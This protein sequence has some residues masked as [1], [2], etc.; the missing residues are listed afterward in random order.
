MQD[1]RGQG[2]DNGSNMKGHTS[3]VQARLLKENSR[4]FFVPCA[5]HNY[6]LLLG[7][8]AKC[9]PDAISFFGILQAIYTL[10]SAS[11]KRWAVFKKYVPGLSVKPL[12]ITR[13][14]CRIDSVKAI[15]YQVGEVYGALVEISEITNEPMVKAEAESLANQLKDYKFCVSLIF[16]YEVLFKVNYVSKELQGETKD[17]NEGM[18]SF[19]KLLSWL[20]NYREEGFNDVLLGANELAESIELPTEPRKFYEKK[21][22]RRKRMFLYEAN[23][24][25][26]DDPKETYRVQCFNLVL[27]QAIQSLK[28]RFKQ[29]KNHVKLF[30]F[31]N[32]FQDIPKKEIREHT[33]KL[34]AALAITTIRQDAEGK[35]VTEK[36]KDVD[37]Y[38]LAEELEALK[39]FLRPRIKPYAL[40]EHLI[41]NNRFTTFPNVFIALRIYVR[42]PITVASGERSFS[43]LKLIKTYL[44]STVSQERLN[45]LSMLSIENEIAK[46]IDFENILSDFA[47]KKARKVFF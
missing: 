18:E 27:D 15:R 47:N 16:W 1:I 6:N 44:R 38:M 11:T 10:F 20:R 40:F 42:M 43:K 37:G 23:D 46:A 26:Y 45:S 7:D 14:E 3:G 9:C 35:I 5:C 34:E 13:W 28:S 39:T 17:I 8:V 2:Y 19:E 41:E 31:I 33:S 29:L 36:N 21:I 22:R 32:S 4:A 12:S 30:G 25:S 24:Q